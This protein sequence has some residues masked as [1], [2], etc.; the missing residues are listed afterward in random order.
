MYFNTAV[1][2]ISEIGGYGDYNLAQDEFDR[3]DRAQ[4][5]A[6]A[7]SSLCDFV[8]EYLLGQ[9][10]MDS[11]DYGT[12]GGI[13]K[14]EHLPTIQRMVAIGMMKQ[15]E[16]DLKMEGDLVAGL[17]DKEKLALPVG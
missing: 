6:S 15:F 13:F 9:G 4:R 17:L 5:I 3:D 14:Q 7:A 11:S 10:L 1:M 8:Y 2:E 12:T 16:Y